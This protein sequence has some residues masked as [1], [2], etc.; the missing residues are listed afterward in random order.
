MNG[1]ADIKVRIAR[2]GISQER[3]AL[4]AGY[5]PTVFSRIL[6]GLRPAPPDFE[7][8]VNATLDRLEAAEKAAQ[9]ARERVLAGEEVAG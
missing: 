4:A 7:E 6:R 2:L 1:L 5:D 8:R 3:V 9:E